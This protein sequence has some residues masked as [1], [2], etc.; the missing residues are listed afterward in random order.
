MDLPFTY[1]GATQQWQ[2]HNNYNNNSH[3]QQ[4]L[5]IC[6]SGCDD[7]QTS[8]DQS[9][10][11]AGV[12]TG[13]MTFSLIAAAEAQH[14]TTYAILFEDIY[15]TLKAGDN[16]SDSDSDSDSDDNNKRSTKSSDKIARGVSKFATK[17]FGKK[18]SK[19]LVHK[20]N[21][22]KRQ[23]LGSSS[24]NYNNN[25]GF[26]FGSAMQMY[27]NYTLS[28]SCSADNNNNSNNGKGLP[29][30]SQ[31]PQISSNYMLDLHAPFSL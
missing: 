26:G 28:S 6:F 5:V 14:M 19:R 13:A 21:K 3:S 23:F 4:G 10:L 7:D 15:D 24:G 12:S 25:N 11:S 8:A 29:Y 16:G 22:L 18:Q 17:L 20:F 9:C 31:E 27:M 1:N 30:F 2:Q